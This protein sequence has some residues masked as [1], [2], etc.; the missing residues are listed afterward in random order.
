MDRS[1]NLADGLKGTLDE[2]LDWHGGGGKGCLSWEGLKGCSSVP[3]RS[4]LILAMFKNFQCTDI[5]HIL[6]NL[7][8]S[9][10]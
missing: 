10:F 7:F 3:F 8:L 4:S 1:E 9:S 5:A 2:K 6:L